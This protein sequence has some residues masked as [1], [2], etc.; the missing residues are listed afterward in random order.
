MPVISLQKRSIV[1]KSMQIYTTIK[2]I[3]LSRITW[4]TW[5]A[6]IKNKNHTTWYDCARYMW[7]NTTTGTSCQL[8]TDTKFIKIEVILLEIQSSKCLYFILFSLYFANYFGHYL[9]MNQTN[10]MSL[11]LY[12]VTY[13]A[14]TNIQISVTTYHLSNSS[15]TIPKSINNTHTT[16]N[17]SH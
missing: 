17:N 16:P 3:V 8:S 11:L 1:T 5:F 4:T 15:R 10:K 2:H 13:T 14:H 7:P 6:Q 12:W 9:R